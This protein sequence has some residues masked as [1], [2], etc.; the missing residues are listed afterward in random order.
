MQNRI[1]GFHNTC[2][3]TPKRDRYFSFLRSTLPC[4]HFTIKTTIKGLGGFSERIRQQALP[5]ILWQ[6]R[7]FRCSS[8]KFRR[9][10]RINHNNCKFERRRPSWVLLHFSTIL[11]AKRPTNVSAFSAHFLSW[12]FLDFIELNIFWMMAIKLFANKVYA[13]SL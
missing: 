5:K 7:P 4:L 3:V 13:D 8:F 11:N 6:C 2:S 12:G 1:L 9:R 10:R